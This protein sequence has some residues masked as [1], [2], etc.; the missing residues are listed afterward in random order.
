MQQMNR[1]FRIETTY[2]YQIYK[3]VFD[4]SMTGDTINKFKYSTNAK[5]YL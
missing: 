4:I 2:G 1:N 3:T 5:Y